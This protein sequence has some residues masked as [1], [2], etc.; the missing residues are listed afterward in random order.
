MSWD[1]SG[2]WSADGRGGFRRNRMAS[3]DGEEGDHH[4]DHSSGGGSSNND[5]PFPNPV[6]SSSGIP[7]RGGG[8]RGGRGG[9]RFGDRRG[10]RQRHSFSGAPDH[11]RP[12]GG[13]PRDFRNDGKIPRESSFGAGPSGPPLPHRREHSFG[14]TGSRP[15]RADP[16]DGPAF[17]P[18]DGLP[19]RD[20]DVPFIRDGPGP[21]D[22]VGR[23]GGPPFRDGPPPH[24]HG[25]E[26]RPSFVRRGD[27]QGSFSGIGGSR[28]D[29]PPPPPRDR[30]IPLGGGGGGPLPPDGGLQRES[31]FGQGGLPPPR[32]SQPNFQPR[33]HDMHGPGPHNRPENRSVNPI[34]KSPVPGVGAVM[35]VPPPSRPTDP[36]R[37]TAGKESGVPPIPS[38][39][40]GEGLSGMVNLDH[41]QQ[42]PNSGPYNEGPLGG[43]APPSPA[44]AR[45]LGS[46]S[47]L[48]SG[49]SVLASPNPD[50]EGPAR[51]SSRPVGAFPRSPGSGL[52]RAVSDT[53]FRNND[54]GGD[55]SSIPPPKQWSPTDRSRSVPMKDLQ[56]EHQQSS[57]AA[58]NPSNSASSSCTNRRP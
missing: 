55:P 32:V 9:G 12:D 42:P 39:M 44:P 33:G 50:P 47:S 48:A 10:P 35:G 40:S 2:G 52:R 30:D 43:V 17:T 21:R 31:S 58:A 38:S 27:S 1:N 24:H 34:I 51:L 54:R 13:A 4:H 29:F 26:D 18:R 22:A 7:F 8:F 28:D 56:S 6:G 37:R 5:G 46:Y 19:G 49:S 45:R 11:F 36:R 53:A 16:R 20:R 57:I 25:R 41:R 14:N 3:E 15:P 23:D